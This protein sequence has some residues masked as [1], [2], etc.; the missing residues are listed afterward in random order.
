M[1]TVVVG[2]PVEG[3]PVLLLALRDELVGREFDDPGTWWPDA[4]HVVGGHDRRAG[5]SC[6]VTDVPSGATALV[7]NRPQRPAAAPGAPSRGVLPLRAVAHREHWPEQVDLTGM[8]SFALLLATT[9]RR[10]VWEFDGERLTAEV[11]PDGTHMLTSGAAEQGRAARHL[12]AFAAQASS[13]AW[14]DVVRRSAVEDDPASLLVRH[15]TPDAVF[16]TVFAQVL[17]V[18]PGQAALSWSRTPTVADSWQERRWTS[19]RS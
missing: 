7:L 11:L 9:Q 14:R 19:D 3:G 18:T 12:P 16:A 4:P 8:A 2:S 1:C 13:S 6:C 10:T 17:E 15:V 5:G